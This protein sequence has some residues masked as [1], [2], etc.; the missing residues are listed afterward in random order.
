MFDLLG[1]GSGPGMNGKHLLGPDA[2]IKHSQVQ[3]KA[4]RLL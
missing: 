2:A 4:R 1:T 3:S